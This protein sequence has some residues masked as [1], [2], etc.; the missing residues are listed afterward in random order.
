MVRMVHTFRRTTSKSSERTDGKQR[1][2]EQIS[3]AVADCCNVGARL[4]QV[5]EEEVT[6]GSFISTATVTKANNKYQ[7]L[8]GMW[9]YSGRANSVM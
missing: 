1:G 6:P 3:E 4:Q 8:V 2:G 5:D 7:H 9:L